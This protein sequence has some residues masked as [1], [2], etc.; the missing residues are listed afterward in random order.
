MQTLQFTVTIHATRD[1]VWD[2]MLTQETYRLWTSEFCE[3]S[4][5]EGS[6]TKGER[7][8]FLGPDGNGMTS[9]IAES[10]PCEFVSIKHLGFVK[11]G[12]DDTQSEAARSWTP[13]F[14]N[15][16]F[17]AVGP[18]TE[19]TVDLAVPQEFVDYMATTWP[20]ALSRLKSICESRHAT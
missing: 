9:I 18:S 5:F 15:Y 17:L 13:S 1:A 14:E 8:R 20:K 16:S 12:V 3:G 4:C 11:D 19:L 2:A 7:I 6:W 10:R